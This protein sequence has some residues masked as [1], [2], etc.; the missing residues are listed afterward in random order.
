M[1]AIRNKFT[2]Y[3][4]H[5]GN[6]GYYKPYANHYIMFHYHSKTKDISFPSKYVA[7][8]IDYSRCFF[9]DKSLEHRNNVANSLNKYN[10]PISD[11]YAVENT[12]YIVL[13]DDLNL[14]V[15]DINHPFYWIN[16]IERNISHDLRFI[17]NTF[18]YIIDKYPFCNKL[19][20]ITD[21]G[22]PEN[23]D[24]YDYQKKEVK[25]V[26][27]AKLALEEY[28]VNYIPNNITEKYYQSMGLT[29]IADLHVYEDERP[30]EYILVS[31][32]IH[33]ELNNQTKPVKKT[34]NKSSKRHYRPYRK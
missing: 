20:Y 33:H 18:D 23:E 32:P 1:S 5:A 17:K 2:H 24:I 11:T 30:Y 21:F 4:L 19:H 16:P 13:I 31:S 7:K 34:K 14:S 15:K 8:I 26:M 28:L 3:D 9:K 29:K 25:N 10:I 12:G 22:T 6:V 27:H